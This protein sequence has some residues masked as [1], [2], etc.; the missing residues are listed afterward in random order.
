LLALLP[1]FSIHIKPSFMYFCFIMDCLD[2]AQCKK[3]CSTGKKPDKSL[4]QSSHSWELMVGGQLDQ[5]LN[6]KSGQTSW[7]HSLVLSICK[8]SLHML[9]SSLMISILVAGIWVTAHKFLDE[10]VLFFLVCHEFA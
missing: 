6:Y 5:Q 4:N 1:L 8:R 9:Y 2:S 7:K 10:R 3:K